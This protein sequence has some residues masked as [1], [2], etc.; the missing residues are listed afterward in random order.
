M[1]GK[2]GIL[3][4]K[5]AQA[6]LPPLEYAYAASILEKLG[7]RV[8]IIDAPALG[9][10]RQD[11]IDAVKKERPDLLVSSVT[12]VS[13][14]NDLKICNDLKT[15]LPDSLIALTGT[16]ASVMPEVVLN[17]HVDLVARNEIEYTLPELV[18]VYKTRDFDKVKGIAY[19]E[20]GKILKTSDR[21]LI[22]DLD[23]LPFP[24]YHLLP[25]DK[26][27]HNW[28]S[29]E[30][31]PFMTVLSSRGCPFGC[32]YCP[33]PV[34]YGRQWRARSVKNVVD[35]IRI[36]T[37]KYRVQSILFRDQVFTFDMKRTEQFCRQIIESKIRFKW[38]CE[39]RI[40]RLTKPL[41]ETMKEAGCIGIHM[42]VETG[43][44]ELLSRVGKPGINLDQTK[45][46]FSA[47]KAVGIQTGAF[48]I[49]GLPGENK[50]TV[51]ESYELATELSP[52]IV[53]VAAV[54]PYPGTDLYNLAKQ[55]GWI[56]S[57]DWSKY[58]GFN[59]VMKTDDLTA[60]DIREAMSF[61]T[62][63]LDI[64]DKAKQNAKFSR[65]DV[66]KAVK[67][68]S[69]TARHVLNR[70]ENKIKDPQK[71]FKAWAT[72]ATDRSRRSRL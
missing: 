19:K 52:D 10:N 58:T 37:E 16:F 1:A 13:L 61:F 33:Y 8:N 7:H 56:L 25:M 57:E 48:F 22:Q 32:T 53:S 41:M 23:V 27:Y 14:T 65:K 43:D 28:F 4:S 49:I 51:Y 29:P 11:V 39:T 46:V 31:K 70:I 38:R 62:K 18:D 21:E 63:C 24:A 66:K 5:D 60:E 72:Q 42:G 20:N 36:L 47:A 3:V 17:S 35:E 15:I 26:Y 2:F 34:G 45:R 55:K 6:F 71:E 67:Q 50:R 59:V 9:F 40:D 30:D 54:T 69:R 68:P 44:P 12:P 64:R